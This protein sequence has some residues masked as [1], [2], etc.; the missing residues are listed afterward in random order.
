[1]SWFFCRRVFA[2]ALDDMSLNPDV[3][4][5]TGKQHPVSVL[6]Q[7]CLGLNRGLS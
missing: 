2:S 3:A 4:S 1:M 7:M 5:K 6:S